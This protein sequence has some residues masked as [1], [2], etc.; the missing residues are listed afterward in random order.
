VSL[1][2]LLTLVAAVAA[3]GAEPAPLVVLLGPAPE[4]FAAAAAARGWEVAA[5]PEALPGDA[6]VG[7]IEAAV[8]GA[9]GRR[10]IDPARVYL[11]GR[12]AASAAVFYAV[13]RRP[14]LWAAALGAGGDV[15]PAI[16]TNRL[17][18]A[19]AQLV[20][21][22]WAVPAAEQAHAEAY[23]E[24]LAA[25]GFDIDLRTAQVSVAEA[26]DWLASHRRD[27]YP[28]KIDCETGSPAFA[29]CY[30]LRMEK[31]DP[32]ARNDVLGP[33]RIAPG[34]GAYLA[35]GG[36]GYDLEAAGPGVVV[37]WLAPGYS[38]PLKLGDRIF[39][40]GGTRIKDPHDFAAFMAGQTEERALGVVV[41]RGKER[42]R[43]ESRIALA[44]REENLTVRVQAQ[45]LVDAHELLLITRGVTAV[46]L[47]LPAEWMPVAINW[48]GNEAGSAASGG[49]W[50]VVLGSGMTRCQ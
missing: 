42:L 38:G 47:E 10:A 18:G 16:E 21:I 29:R 33:S 28:A 6:A 8:T 32:A 44:R 25:K 34:P 23:R 20:P 35:L 15:Q 31:F 7:R 36:F 1:R 19:N 13:S 49:C 3:A 24:K 43:L 45:Y 37:S 48:N 22:L 39:S 40:V 26:L 30:W 4:A 11:A 46:R 5:I 27:P 9:A 50:N 2:A 17:F 14:D 12:G 41:E